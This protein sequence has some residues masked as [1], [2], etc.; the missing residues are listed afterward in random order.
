MP[1]AN[2]DILKTP[3]PS[4]TDDASP[5]DADFT[6]DIEDAEDADPIQTLIT[7]LQSGVDWPTALLRAMAT[8]RPPHDAVGDLRRDYFIGGEAFD[9]LLLAE[10]LCEAAGDLIPARER[11]DL[12]FNGNFPPD[13][14]RSRFKELLGAQKHSAHLNYFYGVIVEEALQLA[15]EQE[16]HKRHISNGNQYQ[17]DFTEEAFFRIYRGDTQT[18]LSEFC[19]HA[20]YSPTTGALTLTQSKEFTYWLFKRRLHIS[21]KARVASDTRKGIDQLRQIADSRPGNPIFME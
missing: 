5:E 4:A 8:W 14:D 13:F 20:G 10:R 7:S 17:T 1:N 6:E 19:A 15:V 18:L 11:D 9:W 2:Q 21:D 16:V 12:L 3:P